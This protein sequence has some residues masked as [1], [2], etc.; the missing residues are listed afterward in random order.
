MFQDSN[1]D[2]QAVSGSKPSHA[3]VMLHQ[4]TLLLLGRPAA[5]EGGCAQPDVV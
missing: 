1:E 3:V 2:L 5:P 4:D